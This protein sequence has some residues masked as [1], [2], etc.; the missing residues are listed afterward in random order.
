VRRIVLFLAV[1]AG[2]LFGA[3]EPVDVQARRLSQEPILSPRPGWAEF[4]LFNPT[5]IKAGAK[6]IL[7]FRAQDKKQTSR[8]GYAESSDGLHFT[9]RPEPVLSP[10][11]P[12]EANGGVE[13]PR[14]VE[15]EGTYYLTY[16]G[17]DTHSAQLCLAV[18][19]DLIHW[20]RK[21]VILPAYK[22]TW[23]TQWTKSGAIV[24]ERIN[25]KWWMYYL[26]TRT[27]PDGKARD[28][29]GV[30]SSPD[31]LHWT[32]ATDA[33]VLERKPGS[34]DSRVM[35][36][37]PAPF[38]TNRGILLLYNGADDH[39]V[40]STGWVLFDRKDPTRVIARAPEP[41]LKPALPWELKGNVPNV[42]F[43]EGAVVLRSDHDRLS[44]TGYYGAADK[45]IGA[46]NLEVATR[47][48]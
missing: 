34:F 9:V 2:L 39:L 24:T 22:G 31:L 17:Y 6:T 5:A 11:A 15:I 44:L 45:Y 21:G 20:Q 46:V 29:M 30:A 3:A 16:T 23:N 37:G 32:D 27:D 48:R 36:P 7:L 43:L 38:L 13:D 4:G 14:V 1:A 35:E 41:F 26:G 33:P 25:G 28:H 10:E 40:Y 12:Y 8:I 42:I 18:S 47:S 19:H